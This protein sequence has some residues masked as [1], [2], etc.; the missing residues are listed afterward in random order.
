MFTSIAERSDVYLTGISD[1][2]L[3]N[4]PSGPDRTSFFYYIITKILVLF[5]A[6][7]IIVLKEKEE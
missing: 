7:Q 6:L 5:Y 1:C 3:T 4:R 2:S